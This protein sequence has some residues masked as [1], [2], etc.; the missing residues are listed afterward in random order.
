MAIFFLIINYL[1]IYTD[2]LEV[3]KWSR[4]GN[5]ILMFTYLMIWHRLYTNKRYLIGVI[6]SILSDLCLVYFE[7]HYLPYLLFFV[8]TAIGYAVFLFDI[9][10]FISW[11]QITIGNSLIILTLLLFESYL[12]HFII[13][14]ISPGLESW[15]VIL[16]Y[17]YGFTS[18]T[19][20]IIATIGYLQMDTYK[21]E[22]YLIIPYAYL[23]SS[24][25]FAIALY[26]SNYVSYY[27]SRFFYLMTI[28]TLA[29]LI[30]FKLH[31]RQ[32]I[33]VEIEESTSGS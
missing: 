11:K 15:L 14:L 24:A 4:V 29:H 31:E 8:F 3:V 30:A 27:Y 32:S 20:C 33:K 21:N 22:H 9:F 13:T 5:S 28:F 10:K 25:F 7:N 16:F 23:I 2:N 18:L 12:I 17:I 26:S 19:Y 1:I 6:F